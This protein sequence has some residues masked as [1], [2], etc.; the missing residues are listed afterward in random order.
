ALYLSVK[1]NIA[2]E[3]RKKISL[4]LMSAAH[5]QLLTGFALFFLLLPNVN[6]M[7]IGIKMLIALEV[8][9]TT[10]IFRKKIAQQ[11]TPH[12]SLIWIVVL[13]ALSVTVIAFL[14]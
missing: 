8:A 2:D 3:T 5:T 4:I 13:S 11:I 12:P 9:I 7:K 1:K 14:L 10:T 6:H